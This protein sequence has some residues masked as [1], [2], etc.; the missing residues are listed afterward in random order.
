MS[1]SESIHSD[2]VSISDELQQ[3]LEEAMKQCAE[4]ERVHNEILAKI[5]TIDVTVSDSDRVVVTY[6]G[7]TQDF[8]AILDDIHK[9]ILEC[10]DIHLGS[11]LLSMLES[12]EFK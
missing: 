4:I 1:D 8:N 7:K 2:D 9:Q 6:Q 3:E 5:E 12:S 10:P 11:T